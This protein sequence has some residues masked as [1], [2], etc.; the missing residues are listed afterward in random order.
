[1]IPSSLFGKKGKWVSK[2]MK[3]NEKKNLNRTESKEGK[4]GL[5]WDV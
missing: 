2:R 1:M 4:R 3:K 5:M